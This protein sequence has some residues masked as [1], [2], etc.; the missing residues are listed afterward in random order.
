MIYSK[1]KLNNYIGHL[2]QSRYN[3]EI[4]EKDEYVL[5]VSRY[6]HLNP[7]RAQMVEK[8]EE[9]K[10]SSYGIYIGDKSEE[11]ITSDKTLSYFSNGNESV[12]AAT[13][14]WH[15]SNEDGNGYRKGKC[16]SDNR[17]DEKCC[18]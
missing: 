12:K 17:N 4:A 18:K 8:P 15:R 16:Y 11:L 6:I 14:S 1:K 3:A 9:Y 2:F 7:K 13:I 5:E 10:W